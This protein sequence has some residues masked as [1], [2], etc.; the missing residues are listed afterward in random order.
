[1]IFPCDSCTREFK[2]LRGLVKHKCKKNKNKVALDIFVS[3]K[4]NMDA[5]QKL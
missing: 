2:T 3:M 1:M 5:S 4:L